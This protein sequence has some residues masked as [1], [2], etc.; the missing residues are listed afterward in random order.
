MDIIMIRHGKSEDNLRKV[1][2]RNS[3][4][5]TD[6]GIEELLQTKK[7][8]KEYNY[9]EVYYSPY[10]RTAMTLACLGLVGKEESRLKE[11]N[12][13]IFAGKT[14]EE[15]SHIYPKETK[16][17][18]NDIYNYQIPQGE[19]LFD[20]YERVSEFLE[21]LHKLNKSSILV[22]HDSVIRLALCWIFDEPLYFYRFKVDCASITTITINEGYKYINRVNQTTV[23]D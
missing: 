17:W 15:I 10:K 3:T 19:S 2:S 11:I 1:Y 22:T 16:L 7:L 13:G 9:E 4:P 14:F 12:F 23:I 6:D 8:L 21:E 20:V 18:T 5:L